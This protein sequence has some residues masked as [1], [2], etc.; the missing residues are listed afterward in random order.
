M[1]TK[2]EAAKLERRPTVKQEIVDFSPEKLRA[3]FFLR[4]GALLIDYI[5]VA[6]IPVIGLLISRLSG[7]DGTQLL[8]SGTNNTAWLIAFLIGVSNT[9]LLPMIAGQSIGKMIAGLRIVTKK[10]EHPSPGTIALRQ[11][12]GY[13][14]TLASLGIGFFISVFGRK[15]RAL[16]D[17]LTGTMVI[18]ARSRIHS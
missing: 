5:I 4:C 7:E 1:G 6:A 8:N 18:H 9:V 10:G 12:A 14:A 17:Y 16:H 13:A 15:G 2:A 3:P 11:L